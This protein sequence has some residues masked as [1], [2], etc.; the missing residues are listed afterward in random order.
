[1][2]SDKRQKVIEHSISFESSISFVLSYLLGIDLS[3]SKSLGFGTSSLS[4]QNKLTLLR[5][6]DVIDKKDKIKFDYF[7]AIR[8]QFA[9]NE[10]A[11]DF[12]SCFDILID[13]DKKLRKL[14]EN[15]IDTT[16]NIETQRETLFDELYNDLRNISNKFFKALFNKGKEKG[17]IDGCLIL[18]ETLLETI[19]EFRRKSEEHKLIL[20]E[21]LKITQEKIDKKNNN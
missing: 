11:T 19:H 17:M 20:D 5:D 2:F 7:S 1:M 6:I 14:Y 16:A 3:K 18:K 10:N 21:I 4:F 9:H 15:K 8:N 12:T 13:M